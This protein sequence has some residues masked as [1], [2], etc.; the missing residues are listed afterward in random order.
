MNSFLTDYQT[1][2]AII[3]TID[4]FSYGKNR[5]FLDGSVT[6][7]SPFVT[8]GIIDLR[9][10]ASVVIR[11]HGFANVEKFLFQLAWRDYFHRIWQAK[12]RAIFQP[13]R[14]SQPD[15]V[16]CR[17]P[18]AILNGMTGIEVIDQAIHQLY[19]TGY[20]HN[21]ARM[22]LASIVANIAKTDWLTG[23]KWMHYHLLDGDLASNSVSWQWV[24]GC[25][26]KQPYFAN[27]NNLNKYSRLCQEGTFLDTNYSELAECA[28]PSILN[29]RYELVLNPNLP[30]SNMA[31]MPTPDER[32]LLHHVFNLDPTWQVEGDWQRRILLIEPSVMQMFPL[33]PKRWEFI[34]HWAG[35]IEGMEWFVGEWHDLFPFR[36]NSANICYREYPLVTHWQG[37]VDSR[38][39]LAPEVRGFYAS[40]FQFWKHARRAIASKAAA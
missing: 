36:V 15:V 22:W 11:K 23:A 10:I 5:N 17:M 29:E 18:N 13:L 27:Q 40:F 38:R 1:V 31:E 12:G 24:A 20:I 8:H 25:F 19:T 35:K 28:I 26:R 37:L 2:K 39:W 14:L 30:R 6:K 4:P 33:S 32:I 7:L 16:S 34:R 3:E 21:H 9:D